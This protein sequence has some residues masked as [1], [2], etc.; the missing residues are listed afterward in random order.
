MSL[1]KPSKT[2]C[3]IYHFFSCFNFANS[4]TRRRLFCRA[5]RCRSFWTG[6]GAVPGPGS[7]GN[8]YSCISQNKAPAPAEPVKDF[9][10]LTIAIY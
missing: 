10:T 7:D 4:L 3:G 1:A 6:S 9:E 5:A 8:V 2:I